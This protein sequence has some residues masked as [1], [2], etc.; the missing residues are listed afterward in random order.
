MPNLQDEVLNQCPQHPLSSLKGMLTSLR[1]DGTVGF[2]TWKRHRA[3][4]V[5]GAGSIIYIKVLNRALV[6]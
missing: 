2:H 1:T 3:R 6:V 5:C 4:V